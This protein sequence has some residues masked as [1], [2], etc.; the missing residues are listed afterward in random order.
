[1]ITIG[2]VMRTTQEIDA[3]AAH[4]PLVQRAERTLHDQNLVWQMLEVSTAIGCAADADTLLPTL[5]STRERFGRLQQRLVDTLA[6]ETLGAVADE[7]S[8]A[9]QCSIDMLVRNLFERTADVGFLATDPVL[10]AFCGLDAQERTAMTP[11]VRERL[12]AYRAKYTVY[13]DIVVLSPQGEVL[14]RLAEDA[15]SPTLCTEPLLERALERDGFVEVHGSSVLAAEGGT[16]LLYAHRIENQAGAPTAVLVLRFRFEDE[17]QRIF[18]TMVGTRDTLSVVL[19]DASQQ[20]VASSDPAQWPIGTLLRPLIPGQPGLVRHAGLESLAVDCPAQPYQ[21][22][23]GPG[24]RARA[25]V[26]LGSAFPRTDRTS[27]DGSEMRVQAHP[28]LRTVQSEVDTINRNLRRVVWNGRLSAGQA[29]PGSVTRNGD[30]AAIPLKAALHQVRL[31]GSRMRE[32]VGSAIEELSGTVL[33][34][35]RRQATQMAQRAA[36][37]LDRN[38]YERANDCRWWALSPVLREGLATGGPA[39]AQAMSATLAD[40]HALY[41]VYR[42]LVVFDTRGCIQASSLPADQALCGQSVP[43]GWRQRCLGLSGDQQYAV[44]AF[45]A[46]ALSDQEPSFVYMACVR[47]P[48]THLAVGGIAIVFEAERELGAMLRDVL[49]GRDGL[50]A[51]VDSRGLVVARSGDGASGADLGAAMADAAAMEQRGQVW[52]QGVAPATGYREFQRVDGYRHGLRAVV[53]LPLGQQAAGGPARGWDLPPPAAA[54]RRDGMIELAVFSVGDAL[55]GLPPEAVI[56]ACSSDGLLRTPTG[57]PQVIGLMAADA[58]HGAML[59]VVCARALFDVEATAEPP[60]ADSVVLVL[61]DPGAPQRARVGL[62]VDEVQAVVDLPANR[63]QPV[64]EAMRQRTPW[65]R[66]IVRAGNGADQ[67]LIQCLDVQVLVQAPK[68]GDRAVQGVD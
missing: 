3:L 25:L 38:L 30:V 35:T 4:M 28:A 19:L 55:Y 16:A 58:A 46:T 17:M 24:W 62:R 51:F 64:P 8:A 53:R 68:A 48:H 23:P 54:E 1:V 61:A 50:A 10:R 66:S 59:P 12:G 14:V 41:T 56:E 7:L 13:D 32:C 5:S 33:G 65:L 11:A 36:E 29:R 49:G 43:E 39:A 15:R 18:E 26:P 22:Y 9:A 45:E 37:L 40:I 44:S 34:R 67:S 47:H 2:K 6:R 42:R 31:A 20:V 57:Q 60:S 63:V 21:G 52:T 27:R